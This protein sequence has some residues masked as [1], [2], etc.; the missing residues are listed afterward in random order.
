LETVK[1]AENAA[2]TEGVLTV[3]NGAHSQK[4]TLFGQYVAAGFH[5]A[6]DGQGG[7]DVTYAVPKSGETPLIAGTH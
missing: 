6:S 3:T 4:L 2:K 5:M 7:T 1:F